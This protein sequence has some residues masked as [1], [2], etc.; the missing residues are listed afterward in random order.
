VQIT[1]LRLLGF[2]SFVEPAELLIEPGLTGVVG[3]NGCGKS[4]LL[5]ALRWVMGE[6]SYKSMR[7]SAMDDVIFSGTDARPARDTAEVTIYLDNS[8]RRAPASFNDT[9]SIEI[10]RRIQR[11]SGSTYKV[12]GREARARDV[13][14]LFADAATGARSQALV[15]QGRIG[16]IVSAK[17]EQRRRI[18]E[19]A[20]GIAG[21]HGRRHEAE[22]RLK[23]AEANLERLHDVMGQVSQQLQSLKRQ[24]RQARKY[25][26]ISEELRQAEAVQHHILFQQANEKVAEQEAAL[27]E[28][29]REVGQLTQAESAATRAES[30]G[31]DSIQPLRDEEA[32]RA[33][34]LHRL[35]V[36]QQTL[37][38]E[39]ARAAARQRELE[40]RLEQIGTDIAREREMME[41]AAQSIGQLEAEEASLRQ[42]DGT[43][44]GRAEA[45]QAVDAASQQLEA[46]EEHLSD[47]TSQTAELRA[48]RRQLE[49][50]IAQAENRISSLTGQQ[51]R[52]ARE[53]AEVDAALG[54]QSEIGRLQ[55]EVSR[56]GEAVADVETRTGAAETALGEARQREREAGEYAR[57]TRLNARQLETEAATLIKLLRPDESDQ[58]RPIV[59]DIRVAPGYEAALGAALGDDL[60]MP[61]DARAPAHWAGSG[62]SSGDPALP[63]GAKPFTEFVRAPDVLTRRLRQIGLVDAADGPRLA[64]MLAPGQRLVTTRGDLWR[65]DG[66]H[67]AADA[68]TAAAKRLAERNRLDELTAEVEKLR[69]DADEAEAQQKHAAEY[70]AGLAAEDKRLRGVWRDTQAELSRVRDALAKAEREAQKTGQKRA[71][72]AEGQN[73]TESDLED[74]RKTLN[75]AR[76]TL[77]SLTDTSALEAAVSDA[78]ATV[79]A[80]RDAYSQA[81]S[82]L[83][84]IERDR[85][86]RHDRLQNI[87]AERARA[88]KRR[89]AANTQISD[90][91]KRAE[92]AK[93]ELAELAGIPEAAAQRREKL[94][95]EIA[96]AEAARKAAA[97]RLAEAESSVR[98]N[99]R[100]LR[101]IQKALSEAREKRARIEAQ[102]EA[103]RQR[104]SER[105]HAIR[106]SLDCAPETC[107]EVA[108]IAPG[109]PLPDADTL[110][111]RVHKLRADR[112][113]LGGVNLRAE[114]EAQELEEQFGG[115]QQERDDLEQAI[116]KLRGGIASLNREGRKRLLDAFEVV[117][118]HFQHLFSVLFAGGEARLELIESDDPLESGLEIVARPPG[119][120]SQVLTLLSG[121]EKALT[122]LAL[123][124]AV[125]LTNPSPIC[126]LDEV[127]APLDDANVDR[128]CNLMEEMG[129]T[130]ETRF[131]VIT[132]HPMTMSR[133]HR[134]FGVTMAERGVSQLVSVDL[135]TAERFLEAS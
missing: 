98:D 27:Q 35:Q 94:F 102:L 133:M 19:D 7:G 36:E 8:A 80:R 75:E 4:N 67:A 89:D 47:L 127:D 9:D 31:S 62:D 128:F 122:A 134:L 63:A 105:A 64:R 66:V 86:Q 52:I 108:G 79:S 110:E 69:Q 25:R 5:E 129:A 109:T 10:T 48:R 82:R 55:A 111:Q 118:N 132:H 32:T 100:H 85:K 44:D 123:I 24:A 70:A 93:A 56:L 106:E 21:L 2:K 115:M 74:A 11:E 39:E 95:N 130:T 65:W 116:G 81:R 1:R 51:E 14:L 113:R 59:D 23:A 22:L 126:V 41:E 57:Q 13:Q 45:A 92:E 114:E 104:R 84:G 58:W 120:K 99:A 50:Q 119:K 18:L 6:T 135:R 124:F 87:A 34:V 49:A 40:Q 71:A 54:E 77:S 42:Q 3:P 28:A 78:Q 30:E 121:G 15:Q 107:L 90:L 43:D 112:E 37:E 83:D 91:E 97:D 73:R 96:Q 12:N 68:P 88:A 61:A 72:L 33:A 26:E 38:Q 117:N 53:L 125:F 46:A 17:P 131:L 29:M 20:A 101:E 60:D 16:E 76:T 103:A